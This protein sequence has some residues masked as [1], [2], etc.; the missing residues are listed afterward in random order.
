MCCNIK[1]CGPSIRQG[2]ADEMHIHADTQKKEQVQW[3]PTR[4]GLPSPPDA[5][6]AGLVHSECLHGS[7]ESRA[8]K[9]A[10]QKAGKGVEELTT[11]AE[12][13]F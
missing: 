10:L 9:H 12:C 2:N 11:P 1:T 8:E 3:R 5:P 6:L 7:S 13:G 4:G